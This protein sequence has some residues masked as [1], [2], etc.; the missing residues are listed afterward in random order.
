M[1]GRRDPVTAYARA[2]SAGRIVAGRPVRLA[3]E[4][5]L[6]DLKE[7]KKRGLVWK[8]ELA[9]KAIDFYAEILILEDGAPFKLQPFQAF[10]VGSLMGWYRA[11]GAR[12][13]REAYVE[14]GKGSGKTPLAAGLGLYGLVADNEPAPEIYSAAT[15]KDQ[16]K[17]CFKDATRMVE[18][19]AEL[20]DLV[21]QQVGSLTIASKSATF[22]PV[23]AEHKALDGK[24]VHI[25]IIDELHEHTSGMVVDKMKAGTKR[26]RNAIVFRIT[27]SGFDRK[28][29]CWNEH[30]YSLQVL[31]GALEN[32]AWFA[33]V[34][35]LDMCDACR[36][37]GKTAPSCDN[38]DDWRDEKV[39]PKANPGLGTILPASYLREQ[40][41]AAVGMPSKENIVKRLNFCIWTEQAHRAFSMDI[42]NKGAVSVD[43]ARLA[44]LRCFGGL[45]LASVS[46]I[47]AL[48]LLFGPD[49]DGFYDYVVR[50]WAPE[51]AVRARGDRVPYAHWA[52]DGWLRVTPG[53]VTDYAF[54]E[55]QV[56]EDV[57]RFKPRE[58]A[59][60]RWNSSYLITRLTDELGDG[61]AGGTAMAGF[62][63]GFASMNAPTK[64]LQRL[65]PEGK[66]RHGGNP[67][68][69]WCAS[70]VAL[71]EDP[72]GN[73][74]PDKERS[75]DK[76]DPMVA[77][78]MALGRA[79]AHGTPAP[80]RSIYEERGLLTL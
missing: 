27:N 13:F 40:V 44:G 50:C 76:I 22:Q 61:S 32:D 3:C 11:D 12:R 34:A 41:T 35:A 73:L 6:R 80:K 77:L 21:E 20:G 47:A 39:W 4:R 69:A 68:L 66:I 8:L 55:R 23:S 25:A 48:G 17:I 71:A 9:L 31:E 64:E 54:I 78:V 43:E 2:V 45:D 58:I 28:S 1:A 18:A 42:W 14:T 49:A 72:A 5:H 37:A 60:D 7:Q 70:N 62:G 65:L 24:R 57:E 51:A 67:L 16:A 19:S 63:Q 52:R 30:V 15:M 36:A 74:K 75:G 79:I 10:I 26:R 46:D 38:C 29:V 56:L 59:F 53:E 33:Y